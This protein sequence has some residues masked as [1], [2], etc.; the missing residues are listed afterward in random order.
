MS[1]TGENDQGLRKIIDMTRMISIVLLLLHFYYYCYA[2]F[3]TWHLTY[4][5]TDRILAN[6]SRSGLFNSFQRSKI[7]ALVFLFISLIGVRGRKSDKHNYRTALAYLLTGLLLYFISG[8]LLNWDTIITTVAVVYFMIT[9]TGYLLVLSGGV[10]LSRIIRNNLSNEVFN[11][12]NETFPQ[13]E[14]L[15]ENEY[16][17]NLPAEYIFKGKKRNSW[18]NFLNARRSILCLGGPGSGKSFYIVENCIRQLTAKHFTQFIFDFKYPELTTLAYNE[19]LKHHKR[20]PVVP[21]FYTVNFSN[22]ECSHRCNPLFPELMND[23]LDAM[24]ASKTIL[25]SIN[26]TWSQ[27]QGEFFVES[28]INLLAAVFWFLKK[29]QQ[30]KYCT[31]PHAI[32]LLQM[33]YDKVFTIL[34]SEPEIRTLINP[35]IN[36]YLNDVM[37]TVESQFASVKIPMGRLS[38]PQLYYILS[39]NDFTL[40]INNPDEPK[41]VCLGNDPVKADALAPIISLFCDR[42]NKIINQ[43][44]KQK[45]A[46]VYDEFATLRAGSVA[47]VIA[48]GRS[49]NIVCIL[50]LQDYSQLKQVYSK[51]E[52]ETIFNICGNVISGQVSGETAKLLAERFPKTMQ[53]RQSLSINSND[54]SISKSKQLEH[55]IPASTISSLSSGE[56]V[57]IVADNPDQPIE[58]KPF[59]CRIKNDLEKIKKEKASYKALPIVRKVN[60]I[61]VESDFQRIKNEVAEI[62]VTVMQELLADPDKHILII[63]KD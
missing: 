4:E 51:E 45:C 47:K 1:T 16:S 8:L 31:L 42:L 48:T 10:M 14:R 19:F 32:E 29:F 41:I 35:F 30:G 43:Q 40:D 52:A 53:D 2:A 21:K 56:F 62:E 22:L 33:E 59:H 23:I 20:Y 18:I 5:I 55:A 50:A 57:G 34:N 61:I 63:K 9:A 27:R 12:H 24:D 44:G 11:K 49:N 17:I 6:I 37:E 36:A 60:R 15:L 38:S 3:A 26:K 7:I 28:P 58:L 25:L 13:E 46:T 54:T 39:G